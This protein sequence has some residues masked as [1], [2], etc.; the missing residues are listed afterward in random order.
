VA[1]L[2][3]T[4]ATFESPFSGFG[5]NP[6]RTMASALPADDWTAVWLYIVSPIAGMLIAAEVFRSVGGA[7]STVGSA[8]CAKIYQDATFLCAHARPH[9]GT[10]RCIFCRDRVQAG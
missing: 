6:A 3:A 1:L 2:V 4:W 10:P 7:P 5:M 9:E 8:L